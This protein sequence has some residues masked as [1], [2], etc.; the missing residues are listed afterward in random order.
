MNN[1]RVRRLDLGGTACYDDPMAVAMSLDGTTLD[2]EC[3][4]IVIGDFA[5]IP[6]PNE[7]FDS[8]L[9]ACFLEGSDNMKPGETLAEDLARS[10]REV[11]R[12]LKPGAELKVMSCG[13]FEP[14]HL[15]EGLKAGFTMISG[16]G[17]YLEYS[18]PDDGMDN[19]D[20]KVT[21]SEPITFCK[22]AKEADNE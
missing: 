17:L 22:A 11:Y 4:P 19:Y 7:T 16:P 14:C 5:N 12:V 2:K 21:Y 18:G 13:G 1:T 15:I 6:F 9:G 20:V 3:T 8:A 10:Y